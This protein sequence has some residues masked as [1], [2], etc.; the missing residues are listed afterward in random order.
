VEAEGKRGGDD[1]ARDQE[2]DQ[3]LVE[4]WQKVLR[5]ELRHRRD[6][7]E[8]FEQHERI[9]GRK[10]RQLRLERG[11][12][13]EQLAERLSEVGWPMHQTTVAKLEGGAR[14]IRIAEADALAVAFGL[15]IEAMWYLPIADEPWSLAAMK[16]R[17]KG[18]DDFIATL[19]EH[20]R[21]TLITYAGQQSER[22]R[23]AQAMN[24]AAKAADR[25][26]LEDLHLSPE[27]SLAFVHGMDDRRRDREQMLEAMDPEARA[28]YRE[29]YAVLDQLESDAPRK[30]AAEAWKMHQA[31]QGIEEIG[32]FLAQAMPPGT[33]DPMRAAMEI[34]QDAL[35]LP[36]KPSRAHDK[37][38]HEDADH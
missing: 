22:M 34:A 10:V 4:L 29:R 26:D 24:E 15:P 36:R 13:Q 28:A 23:L 6:L 7:R 32:R 38:T 19:E 9:L 25:G 37:A 1:S 3:E 8:L 2:K 12:T 30:F 14:P 11:W 5:E 17:L 16:D 18:I 35:G 33:L 20:L 31:G 27:E 21:S